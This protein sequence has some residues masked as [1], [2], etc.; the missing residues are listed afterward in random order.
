[1]APRSS[2]GL[3]NMESWR[4]GGFDLSQDFHKEVLWI[5]DIVWRTDNCLFSTLCG[6]SCLEIV[7][8]NFK[9]EKY[10]DLHAKS[11]LFVLGYMTQ[12]W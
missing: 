2:T 3:P 11:L 4:F 12:T 8:K 6:M 5:A 7:N 9:V 10:V 1:M